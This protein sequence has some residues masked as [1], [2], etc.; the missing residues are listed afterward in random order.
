MG[1]LRSSTL[2][3]LLLACHAQHSA[4]SL[5]INR[6]T[7]I[8]LRRTRPMLRKAGWIFTYSDVRPLN[9]SSPQSVAF[10]AT[11]LAFA[12]TGAAIG[13]SGSDPLL[14]C[15]VELAGVA[16]VYYHSAQCAFGGTSRPV[17]QFA[18][19]VDYLVA[20]PTL[21]TGVLYAAELPAEALPA[22]AVA[23][24]LA[25]FAALV[26]GWFWTGPQQ[27]ML[28]HGLWHVL[29]AA[30]GYDLALAHAALAIT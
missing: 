5:T 2:L 16:S 7:S 11:N 27:Y 14:G 21:L 19:L 12:A 29:V 6:A 1:H 28:I 30:A 9:L 17:V 10:L 13:T 8:P 18:M 20:L 22:H 3:L 25:S 24:A 15:L 23:L 26:G 4:A